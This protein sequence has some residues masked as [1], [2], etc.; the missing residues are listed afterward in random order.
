MAEQL[1]QN[2]ENLPRQELRETLRLKMEGHLAFHESPQDSVA[3]TYAATA[4]KSFAQRGLGAAN[5]VEKELER[6]RALP[7]DDPSRMP[8]DEME[9]W[10]RM[11]TEVETWTLT[12]PNLLQQIRVVQHDPNMRDMLFSIFSAIHERDEAL[13]KMDL[14]RFRAL[15]GSD[16]NPFSPF[17]NL[18]PPEFYELA[19]IA[20][21][22]WMIRENLHVHPHLMR[23]GK[24]GDLM[25]FEQSIQILRDAEME[26]EWLVEKK[27]PLDEFVRYK[28]NAAFIREDIG[29]QEDRNEALKKLFAQ[30][31]VRVNGVPEI[32]TPSRTIQPGDKIT[33]VTVFA[34]STLRVGNRIDEAR[35]QADN[36]RSELN[37]ER[38]T[39]GFPAA[40][41]FAYHTQSEVDVWKQLLLEVGEQA[42]HQRYAG[43]LKEDVRIF[44]E[45][46]MEKGKFL[47]F[48]EDAQRQLDAMND[49]N[50][51]AR[52]VIK[53]FTWF[54]GDTVAERLTT[55][56]EE[57]QKVF[58]EVIAKAEEGF[59][60]AASDKNKQ[61]VTSLIA[62]LD[63]IEAG[64][65]VEDRRVKELL[66][67]Y[68]NVLLD[69]GRIMSA[70]QAWQVSENVQRVGGQGP[71]NN[72]ELVT[73]VDNRSF[74]SLLQSLG[75]YG[76]LKTRTYRDKE[77][78]PII[79]DAGPSFTERTWSH[80][81]EM[82]KIA[83]QHATLSVVLTHLFTKIH[84]LFILAPGLHKLV[85][86]AGTKLAGP[87]TSVIQAEL[88]MYEAKRAGQYERMQ[89]AAKSVEAI[90]QNLIALQEN[91]ALAPRA[92]LVLA[93]DLAS[94]LHYNLSSLLHT[95]EEASDLSQ[96]LTGNRD[97]DIRQD[98]LLEATL[99]GNQ[100]LT[101]TGFPPLI[102]EQTSGPGS[103]P[104]S[105]E[106]LVASEKK[107][108]YDI[109]VSPELQE[110]IASRNADQELM[111][112]KEQMLKYRAMVD[113]MTVTRISL[114]ELM[115]QIE[116]SEKP[117]KSKYEEIIDGERMPAA[118][119]QE[120]LSSEMWNVA[121]SA[122]ME[123]RYET[124]SSTPRE[125]QELLRYAVNVISLS[126]EMHREREAH[127]VWEVQGDYWAAEKWLYDRIPGTIKHR[128]PDTVG[129]QRHLINRDKLD[130][131]NK[132][133]R[134]LMFEVPMEKALA[135]AL[136]LDRV[137]PSQADIAEVVG[138][139]LAQNFSAVTGSKS[140]ARFY[141]DQW[142]YVRMYANKYAPPKD[143]EHN[144]SVM[145]FDEKHGYYHG[146]LESDGVTISYTMEQ[147]GKGGS[148]RSNAFTYPSKE[149][150][151]YRL[152]VAPAEEWEGETTWSVWANGVYTNEEKY[153]KAFRE[154]MRKILT[155]PYRAPTRNWSSINRVLSLYP[156][157][158]TGRK[159]LMSRLEIMYEE[160]F[161]KHS[162]LMELSKVIEKHGGY[163]N[164]KNWQDIYSDMRELQEYGFFAYD[165][166]YEKEQE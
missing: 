63:A 45:D 102:R 56:P 34:A 40:I 97:D 58:D 112:D 155:T 132:R 47:E 2:R 37:A 13:D 127:F 130:D 91:D 83:L 39:Q 77:G 20:T 137:K 49:A 75:P 117:R 149:G 103:V 60:E 89:V 62:L 129:D 144:E 10:E 59:N 146:S 105:P 16:K 121:Q 157:K 104:K 24:Q 69:T 78:R 113:Q 87:A 82:G 100:L 5:A 141:M 138:K 1:P 145:E 126:L 110:Y 42:D 163:V 38:V 21:V 44:H 8:V 35:Q 54:T 90:V 115:A 9:A 33:V 94:A 43:Q 98:L 160:S 57:F 72:L 143:K 25:L 140:M 154:H 30:G 31:R 92:K 84:Y 159:K 101:A 93:Q 22:Q 4:L 142:A 161:R 114:D 74:S 27:G 111:T 6:Q 108:G 158:G 41:D 80:P 147:I 48:K 61:V 128:R 51:K 156:M 12:I 148:W 23:P 28:F 52:F 67:A 70:V 166:S 32:E 124:L 153:P 53:L 79:V 125:Q 65:E 135:A 134:Q 76:S 7:A 15:K 29:A 109:A 107:N 68:G 73:R 152:S 122:E 131:W 18:V 46:F 99:Y 151:G 106:D 165:P 36:E 95:A 150:N 120:E 86:V 55:N 14:L 26:G 136:Y 64:E 85:Q 3:Y 88:A 162:F 71:T 123:E 17:V 81:V 11:L 96:V 139:D 50:D 164:N 118:T 119:L 116:S 66:D 19:T 133:A